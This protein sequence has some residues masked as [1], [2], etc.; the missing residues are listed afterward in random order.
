MEPSVRDDGT[1]LSSSYTHQNEYFVP[2]NGICWEVIRVD[3]TSYLGLGA[4]VRQ[5][6]YEVCYPS[7]LRDIGLSL[8]PTSW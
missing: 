2:G 5:G 3:I 6:V 4:L 7:A 1:G 8:P